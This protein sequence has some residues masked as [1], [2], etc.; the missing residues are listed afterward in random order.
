MPLAPALLLAACQAV[1]VAAPTPSDTCP[2]DAYQSLVGAQLAAVTLPSDLNARIIGP[3][4]AVT[5]DYRSDRMNIEL[6]ESGWIV[7]VRCG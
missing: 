6:D 2:A 7:A 5:M 3:D 4:T 1:P